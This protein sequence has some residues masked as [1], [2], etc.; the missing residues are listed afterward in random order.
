MNVV[1]LESNHVVGAGEVKSPVVTSIT[2][3][4]PGGRSVDIAVGN[5]DSAGSRLPKDD[6]LASNTLSLASRLTQCM[7][8]KHWKLTVTWSIQIMSVP[9][10]QLAIIW[11][12]SR[13]L[14]SLTS[15]SNSVTTP[16]VMRVEISDG[17]VL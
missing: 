9:D 1:A 3:C 7:Y 6:V 17:D 14:L 12:T 15:K 13:L 11:K 10:E 2:G 5:S 4:G 16:D 8:R